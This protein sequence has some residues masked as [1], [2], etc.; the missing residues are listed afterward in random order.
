[1]SGW[2]LP[3][4]LAGL[5]DDIQGRLERARKLYGHPVAKGEASETV[6]L[7]LLKYLP[8]RYQS[9][10]AFVVDSDGNFSEQIDIVIFDR[11]YTPFILKQDGHAIIPAES[12]Y[13]VFEAKQAIDAGQV[14][15]AQGKIASVRKLQRT[16]L[17]I[18]HAGGTYPPK[19]PHHILG[20]LLTFDSTWTPAMGDPLTQALSKNNTENRL[21]LGCIA[22]HGHFSRDDGSGSYDLTSEGR[23]A[24]AFLFELIARLQ[25]TATV[26]MIDIRAYARWLNDPR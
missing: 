10:T 9:D 21:D 11:Q 15:Y 6:W 13:A 16:S 22:A 18:P 14:A 26:P 19:P 25:S 4:L 12:V 5:H 3:V 23:P 20:G 24:T 8:S 7:E 17:P 1:M 2:S